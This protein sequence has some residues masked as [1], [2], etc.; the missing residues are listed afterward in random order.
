MRTDV[1]HMQGSGR[2]E[3]VPLEKWAEYEKVGDS[4]VTSSDDPESIPKVISSILDIISID[5]S[6]PVPK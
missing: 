3:G 1:K 4:L 6:P 5:T 2:E